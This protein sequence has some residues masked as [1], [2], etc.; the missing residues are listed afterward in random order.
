[1]NEADRLGVSLGLS[2]SSSW[3]EGGS[4]IPPEDAVK[5]MFVSVT[6]FTGPGKVAQQLPFPTN[7][8]AKGSDGLPLFHQEIAVLAFPAAGNTE[9]DRGHLRGILQ[10]F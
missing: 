5:A 9:R 7:S 10:E 1:M 3:N 6:N 2:S 4:W 8:A